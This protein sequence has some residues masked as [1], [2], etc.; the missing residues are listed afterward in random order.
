MAFGGAG[1][2]HANLLAQEARLTAIA[3]PPAP[4]TFCAMG[5]IL[6]D[7]KRDYV[8]SRFLHFD[9]TDH[10]VIELATMFRELEAEAA[11]WI[12]TEGKLLG[13]PEFSAQADMRYAGQAFELPVAI[14]DKLRRRPDAEEISELFHREHE[15]IYDF[16]DLD[17]VVEITTV[18]VRVIGR[19][20]PISLPKMTTGRGAEPIARRRIYHGGTYHDVAVYW[21]PDFGSDE[22]IAGPA[23]IEQE[24]ST[25]W[26]LPG[27][28]G[29]VDPIG[30][31]LIDKA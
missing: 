19:M 24:D 28:Q 9:G 22:E 6:A 11:A 16:R 20:P 27:W 12:E 17:S 18:R 13:T 25:T 29:R 4:S 14:P 3:V 10:A 26:I 8:R 15:K 23:I 1:P 5:A 31:L 2:T 30:N 7:V 21:R